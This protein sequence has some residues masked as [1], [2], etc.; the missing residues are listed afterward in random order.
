MTISAE[1]VEELKAAFGPKVLVQSEASTEFVHIPGLK[2]PQGCMPVR[3]DALLCPSQYCGYESRLFLK[4]R[5]QSP[6]T[7]NWQASCFLLG[8]EWQVYS[9]QGVRHSSLCEMVLMHLRGLMPA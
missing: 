1:Q 5:V 4:D 9:Y 8:T 7:P 6:G 2:M 3:T